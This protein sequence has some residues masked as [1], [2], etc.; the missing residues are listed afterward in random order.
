MPSPLPSPPVARPRP[1]LG[2]EALL[3]ARFELRQLLGSLRTVWSMAIYA[4]FAGLALLTMLWSLEKLESEVR[5]RSGGAALPDDFS[6][7]A[8]GFLLSSLGWGDEGLAA[9]LIR[10]QVPL[11][12]VAFFGIASWVLPL[13]VA[14]V[15]F[16]QFSELSTRGAR[17]ALLRTRRT[18]YFLGKAGA[19]AGAV[20]LLLALM[21]SLLLGAALWRQSPP[22]PAVREALRCWALM[23]VLALPYLGLTA[24]VSALTR[25]AVAFVAT[26]GVWIGLSIGAAWASRSALPQLAQLFPWSHAPGLIARYAPAVLRSTGALL[27]IAAVAYGSALLVVRRRDV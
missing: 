9:E 24:L 4:G 8:A 1:T 25:P 14:L 15:S 23:T 26:F 18:G 10:D 19:A 3:V 17:F 5:E 21:W 7:Q 11:L 2:A 13:L 6:E 22:L 27:A 12:F 20:A 16:D